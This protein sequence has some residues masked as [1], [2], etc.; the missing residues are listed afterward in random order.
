MASPHYFEKHE[1]SSVLEHYSSNAEFGLPQREVKLREKEYGKNTTPWY[2]VLCSFASFISPASLVVL[3][4]ILLGSYADI[5]S[6]LFWNTVILGGLAQQIIYII[7]RFSKVKNIVTS[8]ITRYQATPKLTTVRRDGNI[9]KVSSKELVPGDIIYMEHGEKLS[10]DVRILSSDKLIMDESFLFGPS[11]SRTAKSN[12]VETVVFTAYPSNVAFGGSQVI[13][14]TAKALVLHTTQKKMHTIHQTSPL[15]SPLIKGFFWQSGL[16]LIGILI[17]LL[18]GFTT[19][20]PL[21]LWPWFFLIITPFYIPLYLLGL[22]LRT[23]KKDFLFPTN[24]VV[25]KVENFICTDEKNAVLFFNKEEIFL[26]DSQRIK[27]YETMVKSFL[28]LSHLAIPGTLFPVDKH[29]FQCSLQRLT[30]LMKDQCGVHIESQNTSL[31]LIQEA[32]HYTLENNAIGFESKAVYASASNRDEVLLSIQTTA[33]EP[34]LEHATYIW[35]IHEKSQKRRFFPNEKQKLKE[36]STRLAEEGYLLYALT[37]EESGLATNTPNVFTYVG[38]LAIPQTTNNKALTELKKTQALGLKATLVSYTSV[39]KTFFA[40]KLGISLQNIIEAED[41]KAKSLQYKTHFMDEQ[42]TLVTH[43]TSD[44][45]LT[46][47]E[48]KGGIWVEKSLAIPKILSTF[49]LSKQQTIFS[50]FTK[51]M[52]SA[53]AF[54]Q[55][56]LLCLLSGVQ[57]ISFALFFVITQWFP[58][59]LTLIGSILLT[60][61]IFVCALFF[62]RT[63]PN[64]KSELEGYSMRPTLSSSFAKNMLGISLTLVLACVVVSIYTMS[65][66]DLS[67]HPLILAQTS[68]EFTTG[69][70]LSWTAI[71]AIPAFSWI[72]H[73]YLVTFPKL[74]LLFAI[75][76]LGFSTSLLD[77]SDVLSQ[78]GTYTWIIVVLAMLGVLL[79]S[80]KTITK[81]GSK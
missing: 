6:E 11:R 9:Y 81:D 56:Q 55:Y 52:G 20:I 63:Y 3:G 5:T 37:L 54:N 74:P 51:E 43:S 77:T 57:T 65:K 2:P 36:L 75:M 22:Q 31:S 17:I 41:I 68:V 8:Y 64:K 27:K 78:S 61:F 58:V 24:H 62:A 13:S 60:P 46:L 69:L 7:V 33:P 80:N 21:P 49:T 47:I 12:D 30:Q 66:S 35:D 16:I 14:G 25:T 10:C 39:P 23:G 40:E 76:V 18:L 19:G 32:S 70:F 59:S 29:E 4:V 28:E 1:A 42:L 67:I 38:F 53:V 45:L 73:K 34:A 44:V 79:F 72:S 50:L 48:A 15:V 26:G 71:V